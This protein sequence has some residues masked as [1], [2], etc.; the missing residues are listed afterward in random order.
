MDVP[1]NDQSGL[2]HWVV[3]GVLTLVASIFG[4]NWNKLNSS[5]DKLSDKV[6]EKMDTEEV[7]R[8]FLETAVLH[9]ADREAQEDMHAE[10]RK[11]LDDIYKLLIKI[12]R[13]IGDDS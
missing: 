10:N 3:T 1:G 2:L 4:W 11:R 13:N 7:E 5:V 6:D 12:G 9:K 8:R